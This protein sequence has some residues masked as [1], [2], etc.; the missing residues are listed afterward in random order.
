MDVAARRSAVRPVVTL[1]TGAALISFAPILVKAAGSHGLG[2]T[3]I[4]FWRCLLGATILVT[5][6][7]LRRT[8]T[9]LP[10]RVMWPLVAAGTAFAADLFVW[11]RSIVLAGA[12]MAT[13]LGATQVF[14]TAV[15]SAVF[16]GERPRPSF[17]VAAV[18]AMAGVVMLV[19]V[20]SR[21]E[22]TADYLTG[23]AYGLATGM[24][25]AV[26]LVCVRTAG[27]RSP[28]GSTMVRLA[29][30]SMVASAGLGVALV[31]EGAV[32]VPPDATTWVYLV[33]LAVIAQSLGWWT[34]SKSLVEIEGAIGGLVLLLQ[35]VL[36][37]VWGVL[38]FGERLEPLQIIGAV[39]TL[40]AIRLGSLR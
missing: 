9:K 12:G 39:V 3:A 10:R 30:L 26:F 35:P 18:A 28:G 16:F 32:S 21:V 4:G 23:V 2:P 38:L 31:F 13:I 11:H 5:A 7:T 22:F 6:A 14:G 33:L 20:G 34:I 24:V 1:A 36:A 37:T 25:Y 15:L 17:V 19:G 8:S 27:R 40:A 29:W